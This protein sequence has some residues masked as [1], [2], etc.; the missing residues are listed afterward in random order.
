MLG[1]A[2]VIVAFMSS[3]ILPSVSFQASS[4]NIFL[5]ENASFTEEDFSRDLSYPEWEYVYVYPSEGEAQNSSHWGEGRAYWH[6]SAAVYDVLHTKWDNDIEEEKDK[7]DK[8]F[9]GVIIKPG[10]YIDW[11]T[12]D[13]GHNGYI[14]IVGENREKV[15]ISA[16]NASYCFHTSNEA[17]H[18]NIHNL[19]VEY[20]GRTSADDSG[21]SIYSKETHIYDC[22]IRECYRQGIFVKGCNNI[23][24]NCSIYTSCYG[25]KL[26]GNNNKIEGCDFRDNNLDIWVNGGNNNTISG[27]N[28]T[29]SGLYSP[30]KIQQGDYNQI[31]RIC[32][33]STGKSITGFYIISSDHNNL[34]NCE[35]SNVRANG[36]HIEGSSYNTFLNCSVSNSEGNGFFI[37][38]TATSESSYNRLLYCNAIDCNDTGIEIVGS[39]ETR[40]VSSK[41]VI[42]RCTVKNNTKVGISLT[43]TADSVISNNLIIYNGKE[44]E[45]V[46]NRRP[47]CGLLIY[48]YK[49]DNNSIVNNQ[50]YNPGVPEIWDG[51]NGRIPGRNVYDSNMY[52]DWLELSDIYGCDKYPIEPRYRCKS[53]L[54][55]YDRHPKPF[56]VPPKPIVN[57]IFPLGGECFK[58]DKINI[59]WNASVEAMGDTNHELSMSIYYRDWKDRYLPDGGWRLINET[60]NKKGYYHWNI[61]DRIEYPDGFYQINIRYLITQRPHLFQFVE[62]DLSY[63]KLS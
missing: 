41:N 14:D 11:I 31:N 13:I 29:H 24:Y 22:G 16:N 12:I 49:C 43:W 46:G 34:T 45:I 10:N 47:S 9:R 37:E 17:H 58:D 35:I 39:F 7:A 3:P 28:I 15:V 52:D 6:P 51:N 1:L 30:V 55:N 48:D 25:L 62:M 26:E 57:I 53:I 5:S 8:L 63:Q 38:N 33:K 44:D 32:I 54:G 40:Q 18:I 36:F 23:I 21:F 19:T 56:G 50:F 27:C 20:S 61:S 59:S 60:D 42:A 4:N 2:F